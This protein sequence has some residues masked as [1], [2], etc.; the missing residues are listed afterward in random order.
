LENPEIK[1]KKEMR[2]KRVRVKK[3]LVLILLFLTG[4]AKNSFFLK[5]KLRGMSIPAAQKN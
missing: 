3:L 2:I 5:N 1:A 4:K